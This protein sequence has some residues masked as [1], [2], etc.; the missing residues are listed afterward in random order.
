LTLIELLVVVAILGILIALLLVGVQKAR[1]TADRVGVTNNL[2]QMGIAFHHYHVV[3]KHLPTESGSNPSF[4]SAVLPYMEEKNATS[5]TPIKGFLCP[6]RRGTEVGPKR[7]FG[8]PASTAVDSTGPS[9]LD[10]SNPVSITDITNGSSNTYLLTSVWMDPQYYKG[11]DQT[12]LGWTQKLNARQYGAVI[13]E[14]R[15]PTGSN[16]YLGG[17]YPGSLPILYADGHVSGVLYNKYTN[18]WAYN[19]PATPPATPTTPSTAPY[20]FTDGGYIHWYFH[21]IEQDT[22]SAL[23]YMKAGRL[24]EFSLGSDGKGTWGGDFGGGLVMPSSGSAKDG[25]DFNVT[26]DQLKT[27]AQSIADL[28]SNPT[29][30]NLLTAI[31]MTMKDQNQDASFEAP[32]RTT[33]GKGACILTSYQQAL[34]NGTITSQ[35]QHDLV[36]FLTA[37]NFYSMNG[38]IFI[39]PDIATGYE[40]TTVKNSFKSVVIPAPLP[41]G[42][43]KFEL[44]VGKLTFPIE[45][46]KAFDLRSV[47]PTGVKEFTIRGINASENLDPQN[48]TAFV[49]GLL[50]MEQDVVPEGLKMK[51]LI[52]STGFP[53][54]TALIVGLPLIGL[55]GIGLAF[56][57]WRRKHAEN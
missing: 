33:L 31:Q 53:L 1:A 44:V 50:F 43:S 19:T 39:D 26:A 30:D 15:D 38:F 3:S 6:G 51:P 8:Y 36:G 37:I 23:A 29:K 47:S 17:P 10:S 46:G 52:A 32:G 20:D 2:Y 57:A 54:R 45:A 42:Q 14:D 9:I 55:M 40:Y 4:Y 35:Q 18:Q 11:G 25:Y 21:G 13:K 49:T 5:T 16:H 22:A 28:L 34:Q 24:G 7:D 27:D 41:G 12:D 48:P 56:G